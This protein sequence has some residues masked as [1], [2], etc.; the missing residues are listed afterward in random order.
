ME[1]SQFL[2]LLKTLGDKEKE[3]F[4]LFA[5]NFYFNNGRDKA[6]VLPLVLICYEYLAGN[7][8][9][10]SDK[11][12][13]FAR[14][15]S[16][17]AFIEGK[18]EKVMVEAHKV[19]R[20][21]LLAEQYFSEENEFQ[22]TLDLA[23]IV[24]KRGLKDRHLKL[25]NKG[26]ELLNQT[27]A[28]NAKY[29]LNQICLQSEIHDLESLNNKKKG[30]INIPDLLKSIEMFYHFRRI[31][32]LNRF[33]LQQMVTI[34][35]V[36]EVVSRN[37]ADSNIP[38]DC[39]KE[40]CHL[41]LNAEVLRLLQKKP[42]ELSDIQGMLEKIKCYETLL[43]W[44]ARLGFYTYLRNFCII[45]ISNS[46]NP[47]PFM[48]LQFEIMMN[49]LQDGYLHYEGKL[50]PARYSSVCSMAIAVGKSDW[51]N[52][53]IEQYKNEIHGENEHQDIYR[54]NKA[55]YLFAIQDFESCLDY[56]PE[57][58]SF[59]DIL[60]LSKRL[61]LKALYELNSDLLPYKLDAFK[62][63][64]SRTSGKVL[65]ENIQQKNLDFANL[66]LQLTKSTPGDEKRV[67]QLLKRIQE[68]NQ[69]WEWQWLKEKAE[70]LKKRR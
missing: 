1:N 18:L 4:L 53:F 21:F 26:K 38:E 52:N 2:E 54:Y 48:E 24:R 9:Q 34:I 68:K 61:E 37:L 32:L 27:D 33:V 12:E 58:S 30:D 69:P 56:I 14:L 10:I 19:L 22:Q 49:N 64:L 44:E 36:D 5:S 42:L 45:V 25:L 66:L 17:Q 43:D 67:A 16:N 63:F 70:A 15:F 62:M 51:A 41:L 35:P 39:L 57:T 23:D 55:V 65:S 3:R 40:N 31:E 46:D 60:L 6:L 20:T 29:Y 13:V 11:K 47:Q 28:K 59:A 50:P 8:P 7:I